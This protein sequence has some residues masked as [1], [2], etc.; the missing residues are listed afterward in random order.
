MDLIVK[1]P[2]TGVGLGVPIPIADKEGYAF[3]HSNDSSAP[4]ASAEESRYEIVN[5]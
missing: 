2:D 3:S 5:G 4:N 1:V